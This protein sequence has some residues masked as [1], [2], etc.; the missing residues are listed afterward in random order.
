M[1]AIFN[2]FLEN[3]FTEAMELSQ[4]S[5]VLRVRPL[6]PHPPSS[7]LCEYHVHHLR[8][9]H[10]GARYLWSALSRRLFAIDRPAV[11]LESSLSAEPT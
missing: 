7:Y 5:A 9:T 11:V 10:S 4:K 8:R 3:A 6:P 1:D 2:R